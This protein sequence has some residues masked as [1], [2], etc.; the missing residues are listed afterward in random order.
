MPSPGAVIGSSLGLA[1][2]SVSPEPHGLPKWKS[3]AN[4]KERLVAKEATTDVCYSHLSPRSLCDWGLAGCAS[5]ER[6]S[7]CARHHTSPSLG[8]SLSLL[9]SCLESLLEFEGRGGVVTLFM[10]SL[11]FPAGRNAQTP[12]AG[13][14]TWI[15]IL[16]LPPGSAPQPSMCATMSSGSPSGISSRA[17][18]STSAKDSSTR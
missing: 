3:G 2:Q 5:W 13:F 14:T 4:G 8:P 18:C 15:T 7:P 6:A 11:M 10:L 17:L 16:G 9:A 12:E 1:V